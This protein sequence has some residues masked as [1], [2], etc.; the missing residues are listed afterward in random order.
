MGDFIYNNLGKLI[1]IGVMLLV[2]FMVY[3]LYFLEVESRKKEEVAQ[4]LI[5]RCVEKGGKVEQVGSWY[6]ST[7]L[8]C[9]PKK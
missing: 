9:Y 8:V 3:W 5:D 6:T 2:L 7:Y 1:V 4:A